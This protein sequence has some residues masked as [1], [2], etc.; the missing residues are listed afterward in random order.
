LMKIYQL[1]VN[2]VPL[3]QPGKGKLYYDYRYNLQK[4]GISTLVL[5]SILGMFIYLDKRRHKLGDDIIS[6][7]IQI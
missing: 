4:V 2:P 1:P 6:E 7:E 5:L 3:P